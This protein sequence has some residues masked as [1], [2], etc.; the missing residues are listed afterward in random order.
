MIRVLVADDHL[1]VLEAL[2]LQ[3]NAEADMTVVAE[4]TNGQEAMAMALEHRPDVVL[5]DIAM[6]G[7]NC[8]DALR[9]IH[10]KVPDARSIVFTGLP[11][12]SYIAESIRAGASGFVCK[13]GGFDRMR[14][15]IHDVMAGRL[16]YPPGALED[17]ATDQGPVR[18]GQPVRSPLDK[19]TVREREL[20]GVLAQGYSLKE[21][22]VILNVS[23]KTADKHKA[24][25]MKKLGIHDRVEL[26]RFA[27]REKIIQA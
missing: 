27:I 5:M 2:R 11:E 23:Y 22:A 16:H 14:A 19:L 9:R 20:L 26:A 4:A 1:I 17:M 24:A 21:A 6:P 13:G 18:L 7:I 8:F 12:N 25:L 10:E 15:A 3:I